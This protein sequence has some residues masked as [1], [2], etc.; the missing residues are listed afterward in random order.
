LHAKYL[1]HGEENDGPGRVIIDGVEI[2][3]GESMKSFKCLVWVGALAGLGTLAQVTLTPSRL[4]ARGPVGLAGGVAAGLN[5]THSGLT[6]LS[7]TPFGTQITPTNQGPVGGRPPGVFGSLL[8][9]PVVSRS[10]FTN[11][12]NGLNIRNVPYTGPSGALSTSPGFIGPQWNG[13][14]S[15]AGLRPTSFYTGAPGPFMV[16]ESLGNPGQIRLMPPTGKKDVYGLAPW[17]KFNYRSIS[18]YGDLQSGQQ[19]APAENSRSGNAVGPAKPSGVN[20]AKTNIGVPGAGDA[21]APFDYHSL[22]AYGDLQRDQPRSS[23]PENAP[24]GPAT[25]SPNSPGAGNRPASNSNGPQ[26][27]RPPVQ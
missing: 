10:A 25:G 19:N 23:A 17:P 1:N 16:P 14:G 5:P 8:S 13:S 11:S 27:P 12:F 9:Q 21:A 18:A 24:A 26:T 7:T 22:S 15:A 4:L 20:P 6:A 3:G 2:D